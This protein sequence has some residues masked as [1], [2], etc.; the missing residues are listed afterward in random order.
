MSVAL[1]SSSIGT[2]S[3]THEQAPAGK[4]HVLTGRNLEQNQGHMG[5]TLVLMSG[6]GKGGGAGEIGQEGE[7]HAHTSNIAL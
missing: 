3:L 1:K 6:M 2:Q 4:T 5:E 7:A